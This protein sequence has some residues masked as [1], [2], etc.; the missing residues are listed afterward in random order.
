MPFKLEIEKAVLAGYSAEL[1]AKQFAQ[2]YREQSALLI[3]NYEPNDLYEL[4]QKL[5]GGAGSP[6]LRR[7]GK[8][9]VELMWDALSDLHSGQ[10]ENDVSSAP[11]AA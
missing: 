11:S 2:Q 3:Q 7:D 8:R 6:I 9:W 4:V 1:W 10:G 5:P